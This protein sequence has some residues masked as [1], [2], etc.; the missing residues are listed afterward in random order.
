MSETQLTL[1]LPD[2]HPEDV[3]QTLSESYDWGLLDLNIPEIHKQTLGEEVKVCILDSGKSEHFETLPAT[4]DAAN[5]TDSDNLCDAHGHSTVISGIIAAQKD[6]QGIVG[7]APKSKLYF[8]KSIDDGGRGDPSAMIKGIRWALEKD[9]DIISISAGMWVDF[10]PLHA[11]IKEAYS[12]DKIIVAAAG[13]SG[14]QYEDVAYPARYPEVIAVAAY[15]KKRKAATF[16]S[17]GP[18]VKF[19]MPGV[20]IYSTYLRNSYSRFQGTSFACP[21]MAGV[22]ALILSKHKSN[23]SLT[24]CTNTVQVLEHLEKYAIDL[25]DHNAFGFGSVDIG[26]A[27]LD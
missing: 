26:R 14:T 10:K 2:L 8:A 4:A 3:M 16:S 27:I 13:N 25:G 20:D 19:S 7:I 24:P 1:R 5:F 18:S 9:V 11:I 15:D 12:A 22:I 6:D 21:I 17:H 23:P